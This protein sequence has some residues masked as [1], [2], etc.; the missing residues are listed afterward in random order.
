MGGLKKHREWYPAVNCAAPNQKY[1][2]VEGLTR[3]DREEVSHF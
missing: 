3:T 1:I 2:L